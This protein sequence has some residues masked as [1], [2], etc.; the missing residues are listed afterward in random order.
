MPLTAAV[1]SSSDSPRQGIVVKDLHRLFADELTSLGGADATCVAGRGIGRVRRHAVP[2][3]GSPCVDV[4]ALERAR[5]AHLLAPARHPAREVARHVDDAH[6]GGKVRRPAGVV[7]VA[8]DQ[9]ELAIT[10][11]DPRELGPEAGAHGRVADGARDVRVLELQV[12]ADVDDHGTLGALDLD[13]AGRERL[14]LRPVR[15]QWPAVE[16]D[17]R[18]EVR[19]TPGAVELPHRARRDPHLLSAR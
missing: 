14:D 16:G 11:G 1:S 19:R 10:A 9:H 12:G 2:T 7:V 3:R 18:L 8:A 4:D 5:R 17:D 15:A 6:R 13:L